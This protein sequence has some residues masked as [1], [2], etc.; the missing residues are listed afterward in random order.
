MNKADGGRIRPKGSNGFEL[1]SR[2]TDHQTSISPESPVLSSEWLA[3]QHLETMPALPGNIA[4]GE[5]RVVLL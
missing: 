1:S 5:R 4:N 3:R 2:G